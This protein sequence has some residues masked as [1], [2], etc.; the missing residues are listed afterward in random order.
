M[1]RRGGGNHARRDVLRLML[2][3]VR[4]ACSSVSPL[5]ASAGTTLVAWDSYVLDEDPAGVLGAARTLEETA[6]G[7]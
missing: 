2:V 6:G 1:A 3:S 4:A 7:D 5:A